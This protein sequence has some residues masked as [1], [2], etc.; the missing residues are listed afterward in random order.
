M[1]ETFPWTWE[2]LR[3]VVTELNFPAGS[4]AVGPQGILLAD[5]TQQAAPSMGILVSESL[6]TELATQGW[7]SDGHQLTSPLYP[8][9]HVSTQILGACFDAPPDEVIRRAVTVDSVQVPPR[10]LVN[11]AWETV[12]TGL[13]ARYR[14]EH[15]SAAREAEATGGWAGYQS[16]VATQSRKP[17]RRL[18]I[19]LVVVGL[20][21]LAA[22]NA[23][24]LSDEWGHL[25]GNTTQVDAEIVTVERAD[26]NCENTDNVRPEWAVEYAWTFDGRERTATTKRC[27]KN[28]PRSGAT[29]V[30]IDSDGELAG[31]EAPGV[32][33]VAIAIVNVLAIALVGGLVVITLRTFGGPRRSRRL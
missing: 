4:Y 17:G 27:S 5:G 10:S 1:A 3:G 2:R 29:T 20:A 8:E 33:V 11:D 30:W 26:E 31:T 25:T 24:M 21:V 32:T 18:V 22:I 9:L 14:A 16:P 19:G 12:F 7:A 15:P 28:E 6:F 23:T 13:A